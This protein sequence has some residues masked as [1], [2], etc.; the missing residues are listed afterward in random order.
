MY[1][2]EKNSNKTKMKLCGS[3]FSSFLL[4][5]YDSEIIYPEEKL[6]IV[7]YI[8]SEIGVKNY[9]VKNKQHLLHL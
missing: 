8:L 3:I 9:Y 1:E 5:N 6:N 4:K 7:S 2:A